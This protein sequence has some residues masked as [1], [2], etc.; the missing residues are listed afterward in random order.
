MWHRP[1]VD[2]PPMVESGNEGCGQVTD[3]EQQELQDWRAAMLSDLRAL[4]SQQPPG[5]CWR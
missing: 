3:K 1:N 2:S 5:H 4:T